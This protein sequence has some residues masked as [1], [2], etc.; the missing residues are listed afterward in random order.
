MSWSLLDKIFGKHR[1]RHRHQYDL[2]MT[3]E[4]KFYLMSYSDLLEEVM[5]IVD[6][7]TVMNN[8]FWEKASERKYK[9]TMDQC[10]SAASSAL[11]EAGYIKPPDRFKQMH[12][13]LLKAL[14]YYEDSFTE[15]LLYAK[16]QHREHVAKGIELALLGSAEIKEGNKRWD[17]IKEETKVG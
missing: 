7:I 9:Q 5:V 2:N 16:D 3:E 14:G 11:S 1:R 10:K 8:F 6:G 12:Q 17:K 15:S 4:E 13:H